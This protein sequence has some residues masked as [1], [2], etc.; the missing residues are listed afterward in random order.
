M[1]LRTGQQYAYV[2]NPITPTHAA[3]VVQ[4]CSIQPNEWSVNAALGNRDQQ[5]SLASQYPVYKP[6]QASQQT[7]QQAIYHTLTGLVC[8]QSAYTNAVQQMQTGVQ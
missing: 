6:A 5:S 4:Q 1:L 7:L 2:V 3:A 8:V